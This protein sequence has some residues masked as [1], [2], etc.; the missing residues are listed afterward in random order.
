M[1][2]DAFVYDYMSDQGNLVDEYTIL[3][4]IALH[5]GKVIGYIIIIILALFISLNYLFVIAVLAT[6]ALNILPTQ[7]DGHGEKIQ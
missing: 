3:R 2:F 4:E 7:R 6:L 1:S 5:L